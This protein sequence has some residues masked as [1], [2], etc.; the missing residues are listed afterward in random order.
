M[1]PGGG[2]RD[3]PAAA[4]TGAARPAAA[5]GRR[6]RTR[7]RA[8][9]VRRDFTVRGPVAARPPLRDRAR[10]VRDRDQRRSGSA[11]RSW[12]R[13]GRGYHH[14]LRYRTSTSP[15]CCAPA[16][17]PSAPGSATAGTAA[18][19][20]S[21]AGA[22]TSTATAPPLIAQ[23][24]ITYADGTTD[25]SSPT[26]WRA[27]TGPIIAAA[28]TTARPTTPAWSG[29]AGRAPG[30]DDAGWD[31][32]DVGRARRRPPLGRA[33]RAA[34][35][36][37][38]GRRRRST[39]SPDAGRRHRARLRPEPRRA[40]ADPRRGRGRAD[41][42][43]CWHAEVLAGRRAV[44][45]AAAQR[46]GRPTSTSCAAARR[47]GVGAALHLP[48][49][50]LRRGH[51]LARRR[52]RERGRHRRAWSTTPTCERTGWFTCSDPLVEPAARERRLEHARQLPRHPHRLSAARRAARL[53]R[54]H[55][56]VRPDRGVPLRRRGD[57][58]LVAARCR[59]RAAARRDGPLVRTGHPGP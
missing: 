38:A 57:A 46:R 49:L 40:A 53:D 58:L 1:E 2:R 30:F 24:E 37:H 55:P 33:A 19:S 50:P 43:A 41:R 5:P 45:A 20:A 42:R 10:A 6:T 14:R 44:H 27:A 18:G 15:G 36:P 25:R 31:A 47:R 56:G 8:A 17:T 16:P 54:R 48:R 26:A 59:R 22:A 3:R 4:R 34:G 35:A 52:R 28:S 13:A 12:R 29:R 39:C 51:R 11:T 32:G 9:L 7:D 21:T 23:L